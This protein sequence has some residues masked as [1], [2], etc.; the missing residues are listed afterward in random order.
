M[1][2]VLAQQSWQ[3]WP[4]N[5]VYHS[6]NPSD[7]MWMCH[8]IMSQSEITGKTCLNRKNHRKTY[9]D[10]RCI[11]HVHAICKQ[12]QTKRL[13]VRGRKVDAVTYPA[14]CLFSFTASNIE[15]VCGNMCGH[16]I[17]SDRLSRSSDHTFC[18]KQAQY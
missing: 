6:Q 11:H 4:M 10:R 15:P 12:Q 1:R 14:N 2:A 18:H 9:D 5:P 7:G 16:V 13:L 3:Y 17:Y 8:Y